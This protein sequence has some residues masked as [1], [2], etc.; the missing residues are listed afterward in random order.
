MITFRRV[1]VLFHVDSS[2]N[3]VVS[4]ALMYLPFA[5]VLLL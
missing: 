1:V 3:V 2:E 4:F 5:M